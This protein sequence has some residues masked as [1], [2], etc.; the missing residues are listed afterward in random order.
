MMN[1]IL[2]NGYGRGIVVV[3][4]PKKVKELRLK[5]I[6]PSAPGIRIF[7]IDQCEYVYAM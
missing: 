2:K 5:T 1:S 3:R 4:H 6:S 7:D